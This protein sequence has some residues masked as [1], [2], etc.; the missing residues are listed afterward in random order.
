MKVFHWADLKV[1]WTESLMVGNSVGWMAVQSEQL[2]A[3]ATV[4]RMVVSLVTLWDEYWVV[5]KAEK[6]DGLKAVSTEETMV[7]WMECA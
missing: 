7:D 5:A 2:K 6:K 1:V 4:A 3:D